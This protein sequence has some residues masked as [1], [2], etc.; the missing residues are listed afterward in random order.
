MRF[1]IIDSVDVARMFKLEFE[2][3]Y[4]GKF[5]GDKSRVKKYNSEKLRVYFSPADN[6]IEKEIVPLIN[7]AKSYVYVPAF[8]VTHYKFIQSLIA[9][10]NRGVDVR[11]ILDSTNTRY[12]SGKDRLRA[13]KVPV[14]T[15]NYAGKLHSKS[16]VIDDRYLIVGSMNFSK[17]G[18]KYND[19]NVVILEDE[20]LTK[21]YK[22]YFLYFW[23]KIP[24]KWLRL[25]A[26]AESADSIG[27]CS[28]GIDNDYD[29]D[30]DMDDSSCMPSR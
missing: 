16:I 22:S 2:Q 12:P 30:I 13:A 1:L 8:V 10:K 25:T 15:E 24:D 9:A 7:H 19:E 4:G 3:M 11:V 23:D 21:F 26:R 20:K 14:K 17:S 27:S 6:T 18:E 28:D 5:H 29:G